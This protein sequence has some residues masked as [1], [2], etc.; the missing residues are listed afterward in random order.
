MGSDCERPLESKQMSL[1]CKAL[2][3]RAGVATAVDVHVCPGVGAGASSEARGGARQRQGHDWNSLF[4]MP[5]QVGFLLHQAWLAFQRLSHP[6][7]T[8]SQQRPQAWGVDGEGR[9][10]PGLM[11]SARNT[12]WLTGTPINPRATP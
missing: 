1:D 4:L 3:S 8:A 9:L 2:P 12:P 7:Y 11:V 5:S 10:A 6:L